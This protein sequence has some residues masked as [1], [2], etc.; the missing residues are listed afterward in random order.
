MATRG[1]EG[2]VEA[3][4]NRLAN[5]DDV[6]DDDNKRRRNDG[7]TIYLGNDGLVL[8]QQS[9]V[10]AHHLVV[11]GE[12]D[13]AC[14]LSIR[15]DYWIN[16]RRRASSI[17][18]EILLV[19]ALVVLNDRLGNGLEH[20]GAK[21][22]ARSSSNL[23]AVDANSVFVVLHIEDVVGAVCVVVLFHVLFLVLFCSILQRRFGRS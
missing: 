6:E 15:L 1:Q 5:N 2:S 14:G 13:H 17:L 11:E 20:C 18:L 4:G 19:S 9:I 7:S 12:I 21:C 10:V 8:G 23:V 22:G 3:T 16:S